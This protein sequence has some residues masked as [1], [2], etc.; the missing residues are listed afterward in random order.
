MNTTCVRCGHPMPDQAYA[1]VRCRD[2]A[3]RQ[4]IGD[5]NDEHLLPLVDTVPAARDIAAGQTSNGLTV[6]SAGGHDIELNLTAQARLDAVQNELLTWA[7]H[8]SET[9]GIPLP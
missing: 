6:I 4:L 1:D 9:R 7:R 8:I 5:P 2:D 3:I